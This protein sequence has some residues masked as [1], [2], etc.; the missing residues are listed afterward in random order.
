[1]K[2]HLELL[3]VW[4]ERDLLPDGWFALQVPGNRHDPLHVLLADLVR[5]PRWTARLSGTQDVRDSVVDPIRYVEVLSEAGCTVDA[6]ETTYVHVLDPEGRHGDDAV[7]QWA[8]GT[9]LRPVLDALPDNETR[10]EF[11]AE[12]AGLLRAA[13]PRRPW[14]TPLTF[15][16]VFAVAHKEVGS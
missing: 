16:R 3:P 15:R 5:S 1:V 2:G 12:Y 8:K 4:V 7:L 13:Y 6:W 11:L 14:G 10:E 9:A